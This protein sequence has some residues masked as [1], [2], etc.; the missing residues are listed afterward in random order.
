VEGHLVEADEIEGEAVVGASFGR[1]AEETVGE[2][3]MSA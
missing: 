2:E 1:Q 3:A